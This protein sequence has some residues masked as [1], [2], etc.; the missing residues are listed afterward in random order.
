MPSTAHLDTPRPLVLVALAIAMGTAGFS[1]ARL[2]LDVDR[3]ALANA[4]GRGTVVPH[5]PTTPEVDGEQ[6]TPP[7]VEVALDASAPTDPAADAAVAIAAPGAEPLRLEPSVAE[8]AVAAGS[9]ASTVD[10]GRVAYIRCE[11][12]AETGCPREVGV[13]R[14][15]WEAIDSLPSCPALAG[16]VGE[17]DL[18]VVLDQGRYSGLGFRDFPREGLDQ[19]AIR[20]C[21]ED[22]LRALRGTGAAARVTIAFRFTVR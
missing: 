5:E 20:T 16:R 6:A 18:R 4:A 8:P 17:V 12:A 14:R 13:E 7:H 11:G 21:L 10:H 19:A 2:S 15:A 1:V 3:A 9:G 22:R